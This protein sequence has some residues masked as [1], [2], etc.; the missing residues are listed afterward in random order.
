MG[1]MASE[2]T[3]A[4]LALCASKYVLRPKPDRLNLCVGIFMQAS[5]DKGD[6][7]RMYKVG[8]GPV[9]LKIH[10]KVIAQL[11]GCTNMHVGIKEQGK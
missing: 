6:I 1:E 3:K 8:Y 10:T 11:Y 4:V 5:K 9:C 7:L 2:C